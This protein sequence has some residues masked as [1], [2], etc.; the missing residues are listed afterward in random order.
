MQPN[1]QIWFCYSLMAAS[2]LRWWASA[3][4]ATSN[5]WFV[6]WIFACTL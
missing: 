5:I 4:R 6:A 1:L 2:A 3:T